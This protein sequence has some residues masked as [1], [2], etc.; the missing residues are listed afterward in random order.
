MHW[1]GFVKSTLLSYAF[2]FGAAT[3]KGV[4]DP[5]TDGMGLKIRFKK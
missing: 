2:A 3:S 5:V 4:I 1:F